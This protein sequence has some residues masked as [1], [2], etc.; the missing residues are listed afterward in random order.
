MFQS[1]ST[2]TRG[3]ICNQFKVSLLIADHFRFG[4][5]E[6]DA[7]LTPTNNLKIITIESLKPRHLWDDQSLT[8]TMFS[9]ILIIC[10]T[11]RS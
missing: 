8:P 9:I 1:Q 6:G 3:S 4:G 5:D 2:S 11:K 10:I 7:G